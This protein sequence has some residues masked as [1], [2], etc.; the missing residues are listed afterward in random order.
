MTPTMSKPMA[1][2]SSRP[3]CGS[4]AKLAPPMQPM[5]T[6]YAAQIDVPSASSA[7]NRAHGTPIPPV[8][9]PLATRPPGR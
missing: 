4:S 3:L 1:K 6:L 8:A 7:T 2:D 5:A 9:R